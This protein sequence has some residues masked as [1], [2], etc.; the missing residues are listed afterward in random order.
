MGIPSSVFAAIRTNDVALLG[1][2]TVGGYITTGTPT[3][4]VA[5]LDIIQARTVTLSI[6]HR[7]RD[8]WWNNIMRDNEIVSR[9][10]IRCDNRIVGRTLRKD[11]I[12]SLLLC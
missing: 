9:I 12:F 3:F 2:R 11:V 10:N 5:V 1:R 8:D 4:V 6:I 7:D